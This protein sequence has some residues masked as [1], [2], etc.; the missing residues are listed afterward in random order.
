[1][2]PEQ[3]RGEPADPRSD[4]F[5]L[6]A[7]IYEM[8]AGRPAFLRA[9]PAETISAILRHDPE[10]I[11]P[12]PSGPV[13]SALEPIV[14]RCLEKEPE[15]R[16]QSAKDLG[17]A[18]RSVFGSTPGAGTAITHSVSRPK[19]LRLALLA[20]LAI[21]IGIG[22]LWAYRQVNRPAAPRVLSH[23]SPSRLCSGGA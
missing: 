2:S 1:M 11:G 13:P 5:A 10:P 6:G 9:T 16:F 22:G 15:E 12:S 7:T 18:L 20:G 17:F 19:R 4:L 23:R 3:M 14:R 8:L 21:V